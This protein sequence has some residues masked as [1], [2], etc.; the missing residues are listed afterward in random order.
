MNN[1]RN[2][3][4]RAVIK[5]INPNTKNQTMQA[6]LLAGEIKG[7]MEH[8]E[9]YGFTTEAELNAFCVE[10]NSEGKPLTIMYG[11]ESPI[12]T[13]I[14]ADELAAYRA[15]HAY[16]GTTVI[17]PDDALAEVEADYIVS[18]KAYIEKK[19]TAIESRLNALEISEAL[20]GE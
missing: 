20:E 3:L 5:L 12:E 19:L 15:L 18:P 11:L 8:M 10:K 14:P 2:L 17:T 4:A 6:G 1:I 16:D 13:P 9:P 7:D